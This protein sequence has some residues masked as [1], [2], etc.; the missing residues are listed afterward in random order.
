MRRVL[1]AIAGVVAISALPGIASA[2][3]DLG[4]SNPRDGSDLRR[5]PVQITVTLTEAP[6]DGAE[7]R[8]TDGCERKVPGTVSV[9]G[10]DIVL[11]VDGGEPGRWKVSYQARSAVDGHLTRGTLDFTVSGQKECG[12]EGAGGPEDE[13]DAGDD[14]GIITN[15]NPPDEGISWLAWAGGGTVLLVALAL[16]LRR[17]GR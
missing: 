3:G 10:K 8:A 1:S 16:V 12:P 5:S 7:A 13:I 2:H 14:P 15:P 17:S 6:T 9:T 4:G 11:S